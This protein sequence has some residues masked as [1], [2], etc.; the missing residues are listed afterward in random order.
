MICFWFLFKDILSSSFQRR[1]KM[2]AL[3]LKQKKVST[4]NLI[5][6]GLKIKNELILC[7]IGVELM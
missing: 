2:T 3:F 7:G 6:P 5:L 1:R 4:T